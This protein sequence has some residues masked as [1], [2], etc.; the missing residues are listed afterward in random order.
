MAGS[1]GPK[2]NIGETTIEYWNVFANNTIVHN[3]ENEPKSSID[4]LRA[5]T[6]VVKKLHP[7]TKN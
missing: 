3:N 6:N 4:K 1:A 2:V 7:V 5:T